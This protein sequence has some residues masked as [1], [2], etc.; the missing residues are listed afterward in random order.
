[1]KNLLQ[2][3]EIDYVKIYD[4]EGETEVPE[5]RSSSIPFCLEP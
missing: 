2:F 5:G 4:A 1:M 3:E